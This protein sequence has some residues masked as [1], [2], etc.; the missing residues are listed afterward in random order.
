[1]ATKRKHT[2]RILERN[3][4]TLNNDKTVITLFPDIKSDFDKSRNGR[5]TSLLIKSKTFVSVNK[6]HRSH[7]WAISKAD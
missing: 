1:M 4:R 5:L 6:I 2:I 3:V 7:G